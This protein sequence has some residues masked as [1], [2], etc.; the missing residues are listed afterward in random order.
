M[1]VGASLITVP[2]ILESNDPLPVWRKFFRRGLE[3][4][5][6]SIITSTAAGVTCFVKKGMG[7]EN[8]GFLAAGILSFGI[9]PYTIVMMKPMNDRLLGM[10]LNEEVKT[11]KPYVTTW[12]NRHWIRTITG[13]IVFAITVFKIGQS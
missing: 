12:G 8:I 6:A 4:A 5:V 11:V 3:V 2:A 10:K 7:M 13:I 9:L 1:Q